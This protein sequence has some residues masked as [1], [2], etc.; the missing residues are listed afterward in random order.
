MLFKNIKEF[1]YY[2]VVFNNK[3]YYSYFLLSSIICFILSLLRPYSYTPIYFCFIFL[4]YIMEK[5]N[6]TD[7]IKDMTHN[8][9]KIL[10]LLYSL[11]SM[12]IFILPQILISIFIYEEFHD[13]YRIILFISFYFI[14]MMFYYILYF[15]SLA[16]FNI[17][18]KNIITLIMISI[19]FILFY[20]GSFLVNSTI[21]RDNLDAQVFISKFYPENIFGLNIFSNSNE[22][23][24]SH[25]TININ[26]KY[27]PQSVDAFISNKLILNFGTIE[28][29]LLTTGILLII[30]LWYYFD[31]IKVENY[32]RSIPLFKELALKKEQFKQEAGRP[33]D[34]L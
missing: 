23:I 10:F 19:F 5:P 8:E 14:S 24:N 27:R 9:I 1:F 32:L 7:I 18:E 17:R 29:F 20:R 33:S 21:A 34:K 16:I 13:F 22:F 2:E 26:I 28:I 31:S 4:G 6:K 15:L 12:L 11:Y 30:L 25:D 3:K